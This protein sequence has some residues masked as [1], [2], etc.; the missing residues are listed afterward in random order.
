VTHDGDLLPA[1]VMHTLQY[2]KVQF[3]KNVFYHALFGVIR[4]A[5]HGSYYARFP[6]VLGVWLLI[7]LSMN[8]WITGLY[9]LSLKLTCEQRGEKMAKNAGT[10]NG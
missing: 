3:K 5:G 6:A 7:L 2:Y 4:M 8:G 1:Y 10:Q 9:R